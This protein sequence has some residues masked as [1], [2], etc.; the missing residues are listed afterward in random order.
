VQKVK[1]EKDLSMYY[2][3]SFGAFRVLCRPKVGGENPSNHVFVDGRA[4]SPGHLLSDA[5]TAPGGIALLHLDNGWDEFFVGPLFGPDLPPRRDEK[6]RRYF[7][8][9]RA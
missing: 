7:R 4:K 9:L 2:Y 1:L 3:A 8:F 5:R 6:S